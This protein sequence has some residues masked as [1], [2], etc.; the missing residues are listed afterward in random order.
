MSGLAS[1]AH[2]LSPARR[3]LALS[4]LMLAVAP[5][6]TLTGRADPLVVTATDDVLAANKPPIPN[7]LR[8]VLRR[9]GSG[10]TITFQVS[11]PVR[12]KAPLRI[13]S[14][15]VGLTIVGP[16]T[17]AGDKRGVIEIPA[18]FVTL[19]NLRFQ[20]INVFG[21]GDDFTATGI[22]IV[23]NLF[24]ADSS[25]SMTRTSLCEVANNRFEV[26]GRDMVIGFDRTRRCHI[27][28]NVIVSAAKWQIDDTSSEDLVI[29]QNRVN[30]AIWSTQRSGDIRNNTL[31]GSD[32]LW[33]LPSD[34]PPSARVRVDSNRAPAILVQR[35]NVE[36]VANTLSPPA[37]GRDLPV[38]LHVEN[39]EPA[40]P[41][42][43]VVVERNT[44]EGGEVGI[45]YI[46][47][48]TSAPGV[49]RRNTIT[50]CRG[51]GLRV[52]NGVTA[53][54]ER[55]DILNCGTGTTGAGI[56]VTFATG[57]GVVVDDNAI[58]GTQGTGIAVVEPADRVTISHNRIR[59]STAAG[60]E[61]RGGSGGAN[62]FANT[63]DA[64]TGPGVLVQPRSRASL[65]ADSIT[66]NGGPGA[67][68]LDES[69]VV[70]SRV[71]MQNNAGPGIDI[72][73]EGVTGNP[74]PKLAN[75]DLDWP[76]NLEWVPD[77]VEGD[78]APG[79]L[80]EVYLIEPGAR[81]GNPDN[82]EG[83]IYLGAAV[84]DAAGHF[85]Y[86]MPCATATI[87]TTTAT[88]GAGAAAHTSEFS[89]DVTCTIPLP[90]PPPDPE[91]DADLDGIL[92]ESDNCPDIANPDQLDS[93]DDGIGDACDPDPYAP[94]V[95]DITSFPG[96]DVNSPYIHVIVISGGSDAS[97]D[98]LEVIS[99][100]L[101]PGLTLDPAGPLVE[102]QPTRGGIF[103][104]TLKVTD[105]LTGQTATQSF[106]IDILEVATTELPEAFVGRSYEVEIVT[107]DRL[108]GT[109]RWFAE[110]GQTLPPG[111]DFGGFEQ[112]GLTGIPTEPG[113]YTFTVAVRSGTTEDT[114]V[115][116][117]VVS[118]NTVGVV[119]PISVS[120]D[121]QYDNGRPDIVDFG[122]PAITPSARYVAFVSNGTNL[123]PG[124]TTSKNRVYLRDTCLN[125][126]V[127]C[128][129]STILISQ[130]RPGATD[131]DVL[132][133][134][135][136][137]IS[138]D[139][140]HVVFFGR[141]KYAPYFERSFLDRSVQAFVHDTC[142][143]APAGCI[144]RTV[145]LPERPA[146]DETGNQIFTRGQRVTPALRAIST[147]GRFV[148]IP[149]ACD[150][151]TNLVC[152]D[153]PLDGSI[154]LI[155]HDRD[156]DE[157]GVFD[158]DGSTSNHTVAIG[159]DGG[160][161]V[162][163]SRIFMNPDGLFFSYLGT[164]G[165]FPTVSSL[166]VQDL[167]GALGRLEVTDPAMQ[168]GAEWNGPLGAASFSRTSDAFSLP[169]VYSSFANTTSGYRED[170]FLVRLQST[171]FLELEQVVTRDD[172]GQ[173]T[174]DGR[175]PSDRTV[176]VSTTGRFI[177]FTTFGSNL[178]PDDTNSTQDVYVLDRYRGPVVSL[179]T[180][181]VVSLKSNGEPLAFGAYNQVLSGNG[182]YVVFANNGGDTNILPG[183]TPNRPQLYIASTGFAEVSPQ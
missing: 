48:P 79:A 123:V 64:N 69:L 31:S 59:Q 138:A 8:D 43:D 120:T 4:F 71:S 53:R 50:G 13:P 113:T 145:T 93:D 39:F 155:L 177:S 47:A 125:G 172:Q 122:S 147:D 34:F 183:G 154:G 115:L 14:G 127:G 103:G 133:A 11:G 136:P 32:R 152:P 81:A 131:A 65:T 22:R 7:S 180:Y 63:V 29:E 60:M 105:P 132:F 46:E 151:D 148:L 182:Q 160:D 9:A 161:A 124:L 36:V 107:H 168:V 137:S 175:S 171:P 26:T 74:L 88:L 23:D 178:V 95:F 173:S 1:L 119:A 83:F 15:L 27:R 112:A 174:N 41:S 51:I 163:A 5:V 37:A 16:V 58:V 55:N 67:L 21:G 49:V 10:D 146:I 141:G 139:G 92:N 170:A 130:P 44:V 142:H 134:E 62:I 167:Y 117:L 108:P 179:D 169:W 96:G 99:G 25:L 143:G 40:G 78:T 126:P 97:A 140:R 149:G 24:S 20:D 156:V 12:L 89:P 176:D 90:P 19:R 82:G 165:V 54:I 42:G 114:Q 144:P 70:M 158:E 159:P 121:G 100:E 129:P 77:R 86:P 2:A 110:D 166:F 150:L 45:H 87:L 30:G 102:G 135:F 68:I 164:R 118:P 75:L 52:S 38:R 57:S 162:V 66:N 17:I 157:D 91:T 33:V 84:A 76:E 18:D 6:I 153:L 116:T 101:P 61:V 111:M 72:S 104:F 35:T 3:L 98:T 28:E 94:L 106:A 56:A 73:P 85:V 109:W 80:V 128:T 181:R